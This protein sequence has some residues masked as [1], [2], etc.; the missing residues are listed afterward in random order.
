M[1]VCSLVL[2]S[3]LYWKRERWPEERSKGYRQLW[4]QIKVLIPTAEKGSFESEDFLFRSQNFERIK[5]SGSLSQS[6]EQVGNELRKPSFHA[7]KVMT[8]LSRGRR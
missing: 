7:V 1:S 6:K 5:A 3:S 8:H 4:F 2:R